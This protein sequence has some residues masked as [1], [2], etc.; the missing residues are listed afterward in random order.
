[1][2]AGRLSGRR[3]LVTGAAGGIGSAICR[4]LREDGAVVIASDIA[5][6]PGIHPCDITDRAAVDAL[7]DR[8][9]PLWGVVHAAALCGGS[10]PFESIEE[11]TFARYIDINLTG[12]FHVIQASARS[13][14]ARRGGGRI[15][16]I[17]SVNALIAERDAAPYVAAKGG[18]R[19]LV[20]AAAVD[21]ARHEIAVSLIHP[22]PI[23]VPR[24]AEL[25]GD[26]GVRT[27]FMSRVPMGGPGDPAAVAAAAAYLL[28]PDAT[29]TTGAEIAVDGGATST[30]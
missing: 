11:A 17:G 4:R 6:A 13:M 3:V 29:Y 16:A 8:A 19:M 2:T 24:N 20:K 14:I 23:L 7:V 28:D 25:F 5:G 15:V 21:L 18:L 12:A 30:F 22:G 27:H 9:G 1:M 26:D 10:G